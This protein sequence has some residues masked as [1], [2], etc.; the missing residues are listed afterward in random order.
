VWN[1]VSHTEG[2]V[3][4]Y[5]V[6]KKIFEPKRGE[7]TGK[8]G[9]LRNELFC[10]LYNYL[11]TPFSRVLLEKLNV[12][13]LVKKFPALYGTRRFI[14]AFTSARHLS[15]FWANSIQSIPSHPTSWTSILILFSLLRLGLPSGLFPSVFLTKTLYTRVLSPIPEGNFL[16]SSGL[17]CFSKRTLLL[18]VSE[19]VS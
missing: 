7:L 10:A 12:L 4:E 2:R 8:G 3:F 14:T 17:L 15:L 9:R 5:R 11:P 13:E 6:L 19:W 16:A 18:V 1:L